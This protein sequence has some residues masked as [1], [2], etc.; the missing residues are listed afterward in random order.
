MNGG[1]T[2]TNAAQA[3]ADR[4]LVECS[5]ARFATRSS[6]RRIVRRSRLPKEAASAGGASV[7]IGGL[8]LQLS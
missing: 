8:K 7:S 4:S 1:G 3:S 2:L 5:F 6:D